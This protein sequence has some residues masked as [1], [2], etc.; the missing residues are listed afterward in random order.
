MVDELEGQQDVVIK[1]LGQPLSSVPGIAGAT[2]LG[3]QRIALVL[4]L[5]ALVEEAIQGETGPEV[6]GV[7]PAT[8]D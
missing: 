6:A 2:E 3:D 7:R 1:S 4:D 5:A 8:A